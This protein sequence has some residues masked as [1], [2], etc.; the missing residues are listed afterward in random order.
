MQ[1]PMTVALEATH[2]LL[3]A[4]VEAGVSCA[5]DRAALAAPRNRLC[6]RRIT[7]F[8]TLLSQLCA[9]HAS[10]RAEG[11]LEIRRKAIEFRRGQV[12]DTSGKLTAAAG[13]ESSAE[14]IGAD[15]AVRRHADAH[16]V[17]VVRFWLQYRNG[18][19][20]M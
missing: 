10:A 17:G 5:N 19:I 4:D 20:G 3:Q 11:S 16:R 18:T 1:V 12:I 7:P 6:Y 14:L 15:N 2:S 8:S 9:A 13:R